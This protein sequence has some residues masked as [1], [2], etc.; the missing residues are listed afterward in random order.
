MYCITNTQ[1]SIIAKDFQ[2]KS[3]ALAY[4]KFYMKTKFKIIKQ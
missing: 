2:T 1:G 3:Q 4:A